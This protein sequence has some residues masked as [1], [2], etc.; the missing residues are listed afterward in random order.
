M[1][2]QLKYLLIVRI[3]NYWINKFFRKCPRFKGTSVAGGVY[4]LFY[5]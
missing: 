2:G 1:N 3:K 5:T 4:I